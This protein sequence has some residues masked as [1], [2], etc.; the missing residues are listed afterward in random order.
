MLLLGKRVAQ[1]LAAIVFGLAITGP[2]Q[3]D[4]ASISHVVL[5]WLNDGVP[6]EQI[7]KI[8]NGAE[9]LTTIDVVQGLKIGRAVPSD[10]ATVDDSFSFAL[11]V[12]FANKADMQTYIEH[13]TH[14]EY[15]SST[16]KPALK[17]IL[18]YDFQ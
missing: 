7:T 10:R 11:T 13:E 17:R 16:L 4:Q 1:I 8:I 12:E 3:A 14:I 6:Q 2:A 9:I 15:V 18:V 5:V